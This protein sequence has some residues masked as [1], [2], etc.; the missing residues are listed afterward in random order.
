[1]REALGPPPDKSFVVVHHTRPTPTQRCHGEVRDFHRPIVDD[2]SF[3]ATDEPLNQDEFI[4]LILAFQLVF[5]A[6]FNPG[7]SSIVRHGYPH[8]ANICV[9]PCSS[10][11]SRTSSTV[12]SR[13]RNAINDFTDSQPKEWGPPTLSTSTPPS[14]VTHS[15]AHTKR[16]PH[17]IHP[18]RP[19]F[20]RSWD[21]RRQALP[22][23]AALRSLRIPRLL[24]LPIGRETPL[25]RVGNLSTRS[26]YFAATAPKFR[27]SLT[28]FPD[29]RA[30]TEIYL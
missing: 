15:R 20:F 13:G 2:E 1:M 21:T 5:H 3:P 16:A 17:H 28:I 24:K 19:K 18:S 14:S 25:K 22:L 8:I 12:V 29:W 27:H 7:N 4:R 11:R 9:S 6:R 30:S 23:V 26:N 10:S